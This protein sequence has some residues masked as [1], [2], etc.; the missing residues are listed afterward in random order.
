MLAVILLFVG[1]GAACVAL[2]QFAVFALPVYVGFAAGFWAIHTGA[3]AIGGILVGI[4]AGALVFVVGQMVFASSRSP[5]LR[6]LV[7]LLFAVPATYAG[8]SIVQQVWALAMPPIP[9]RY[10]FGVMAALMTGG[11]ALARLS[12]P[13]QSAAV[14]RESV[15]KRTANK[16]PSQFAA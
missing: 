3:G 7:A 8:Y 14:R 10:V 11:T 13:L 5:I 4:V 2:Y 9:W 1:L 6:I 15:H 16:A 12:A